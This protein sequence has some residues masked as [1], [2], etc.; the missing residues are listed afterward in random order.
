VIN[1]SAIR[2][3]FEAL[4]PVLNER[5]RRLFAAAEAA[6]AGRGGVSAVMRATGIARSTIRRGLNELRGAEAPAG[7]R[8]R[9]PGGGR[10]PL[11]AADPTVLDDL[12]ALVE[13]ETRGDPQSPLLWTCKS[14][15]KLS[16]ALRDMG[17]SVGRTV[18][19]ELLSK[20]GYSLQ[21]N[22]KTREGA[23]HPDRDAQFHYINER[24]KEALAAGEP[25]ISVDTKKKELVGDFRNGGREWRP[26]GSPEEVRIHDFVIPE[27]GRAAP[28]GVYDIASN[29]A[30]VSVG[31]DHDTA[32]FA[33]NAIRS[34]WNLMGRDRY[35]RAHR[36]LITADAGGSN[37]SRVRL[38]KI[39]LQ[40][41]ADELRMPIT[42]CHLP[43][44]TSKWNKIEHRLFSFITGNWRG[45]P[46][47][48]H[49]AMVQLIA[50]TT[51][52]TGLT[53]RCELD[54]NTYP[55]GIKVSDTEIAA[56]N[57]TRHDFHGDWNYTIS[58]KDLA[59]KR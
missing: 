27:L 36:L 29:A 28:Y 47:V 11:S 18:V 6:A 15:R 50:A 45:K 9:R 1:E 44:G 35:P 32:A 16:A 19:G 34:W 39:E 49:Q 26:K 12:R 37:G 46:L 13:P 4:A 43:P 21:A 8:V 58:P 57:L 51:T 23:N 38:W 54:P 40:K 30:W 55:A 5:A 33:V 48:G 20:L 10:K 2:L 3:R 14:L 56:V 42:V 22:R 52:E 41:L 7:E 25:A 59:P 17:H 53:V 31:I 24:V